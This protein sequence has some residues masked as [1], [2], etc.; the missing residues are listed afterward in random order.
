V[1]GTVS[2]VTELTYPDPIPLPQRQISHDIRHE[3]G[4]I[5]LLASLLSGAPDVGPESRG[6]ARQILGEARWLDELHRAYEDAA[7]DG[8]GW[9][10]PRQPIRVDAVAAEVVAAMRL[11]TLTRIDYTA[12]ETWAQAD[13]LSCWRA[14]RNLI[15]N[16]VRAAGPDGHVD[17]RVLAE[18]GWA[19]IQVDDDGPGFGAVAPG[20]GSLGLGI[21]QDM[22][23]GCGGELE[24]RRGELGGCC[25]RLRLAVPARAS[26]G[27]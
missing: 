16:A 17:V 14:L 15:G 11:S 10:V 20:L 3:L 12:P 27:R 6:R 23:A 4:T 26:C 1:D 22:V 13:R 2:I 5:M 25:V 8:D 18:D 9:G 19:V 24:I 21:V 7:P